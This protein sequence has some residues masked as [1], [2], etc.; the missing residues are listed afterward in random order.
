MRALLPSPR[1][2]LVPAGQWPR[3]PVAVVKLWTGE[4][5]PTKTKRR[6]ALSAYL[7]AKKVSDV[8][9]LTGRESEPDDQRV[10]PARR[11]RRTGAA[12]LGRA[13]RRVQHSRHRATRGT[14]DVRVAEHPWGVTARPA[15]VPLPEA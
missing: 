1:S 11:T 3:R 15:E 5:P 8:K 7:E 10:R 14:Q 6:S 12:V 4:S 2:L 9:R 13:G